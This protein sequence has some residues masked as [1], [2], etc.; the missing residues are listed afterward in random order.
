MKQNSYK[1]NLSQHEEESSEDSIEIKSDPADHEPE[2]REMI[3]KQQSMVVV[4]EALTDGVVEGDR[5]IGFAELEYRS[6]LKTSLFNERE[7]QI[8]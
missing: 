2:E 4:C 1:S 5:P 7:I 3:K 8:I 6:D